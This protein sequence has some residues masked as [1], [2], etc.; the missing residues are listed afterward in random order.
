MTTAV[1]NRYDK[2]EDGRFII[3][4]SATRVQ[5]LYNNFDRSAPHIRRDLDQNLADYLIS[6]AKELKHETIVV[7]FSFAE[8][9][10]DENQMRIRKSINSYFRYVAENE[11]LGLLQIIRRSGILFCIGIALL[12]A[13]VLIH[14]LYYIDSSVLE[15]VF[16]QGITVA[17]WV[18][19]WESFVVFLVEWS[20]RY[21][22]LI[23][24]RRLSET[25]IVFRSAIVG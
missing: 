10:S 18:S 21:K 12:F 19:L 7:R 3:D 24:L 9:P 1:L 17:A 5:D 6:S 4:V 22:T 16:A 2:F 14:Q 13:S 15:K 23:L 11:K 25:L 20:P 8:P